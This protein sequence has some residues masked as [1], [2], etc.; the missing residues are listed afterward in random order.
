MCR[1]ESGFLFRSLDF[2]LSCRNKETKSAAMQI[3]DRGAQ[4]KVGGFRISCPLSTRSSYE[5]R[6]HSDDSEPQA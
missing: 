4:F 3:S 1:A 5:T 6:C 2:A